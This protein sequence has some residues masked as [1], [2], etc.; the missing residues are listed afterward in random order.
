MKQKL[1]LLIAILFS[2]HILMA[3]KRT[4]S[5]TVTDSST[6]ESLP[7]ASI[8]EKG[9]KNGM[10][11][12]VK[13]SFTITTL[14]S[15]ATLAISFM[16]YL[17]Q[18][19]KLSEA[20]D[21]T[22]ALEPDLLKLDEVVV[23]GYGTQKKSVVTGAIAR[24]DQEMLEKSR[25]TRIE[26]ALQGQTAGVVIVNNSGQPGD[27]LTVRIR[28]VGTVKNSDPL[29]IVDGMPLEQSSL[30]FLNPADVQSVEVLKDA[31]STAIYGTR[32]ANGVVLITTKQGKK[33]EKMQVSYDMYYG[34]QNPW[35][36]VDML[37]AQE[38]IELMNDGMKNDG[39]DSMFTQQEID[40]LRWNTNWQDEMY[41]KNAPKQSHSISISGGSKNSTYSSTLSYLS[42]DG[43]VAKGKSNF[44][45]IAFRINSTHNIGR[46]NVGTNLNIVNINKKGVDP[47]D[48]FSPYSLIQALNTP[49]IVPV[50]FDNGKW[51]TPS[52]FGVGLQEITNPIAM[53]SYLN[54]K[55]TT[56]KAIG[57]VYAEFEIIEGLYLKSDFTTE[58]GYLTKDQYTPEYNLD[59]THI[60]TVNSVNKSIDM[61]ARWNVDNTL[62]YTKSIQ[63][64][65]FTALVGLTYFKTWYENLAASRS[66]LKFDDFDKAYLDNAQNP[67]A[68]Q[69]FPSGGYA[70]SRL[71][72]TFGRINYDYNE[73]YLFEGVIRR[74]GS[75]KFGSDYRFGIFPSISAGWVISKENFF[76]SQDMFNYAKL[77]FSWGKNGNDQIPDFQ[78]SPIMS[79]NNIYYFGVNQDQYNGI[80]PTRLPNPEVRWEASEQTN[81]G[82]NLGF[83]KNKL[84]LNI[85]YYDKR[86]KDWLLT[87]TT[88]TS[89][90]I[91]N[92]PSD[93]NMGEVANKGIEIELGYK[94]NISEFTYSASLIAASNKSEVIS[95]EGEKRKLFGRK[96]LGSRR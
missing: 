27:N 33:E 6:G 96:H 24:V 4:I 40:T 32:G 72:S 60:S 52:D 18:E 13:G 30:D 25:S 5:G 77:R 73:K 45:R 10:V 83:F 69:T 67:I 78:Y 28:G 26:Q 39:R 62:R 46:L 84:T 21:L 63:K 81:I 90:L 48:Q 58:I 15:D 16:G 87:P 76:P 37:N 61:N 34:L 7:G 75:S 31:A 12:D 14:S 64:H 19:I 59:A 2:G 95:I 49:P 71:A 86:T 91:G 42:Q 80:Q 57:G 66:Q 1:L 11:T 74:D 55:E 79:S 93:Q 51:A 53:L 68:T 92:N 3:Q 17:T 8:Y 41:Y 38:Y 70:E 44:E 20:S 85:D 56:N 43:I 89:L 47:N 94:D 36:K 29:Y 54:K 9:T 22:I 50:K 65:N 23:V 35:H 82:V 88:S